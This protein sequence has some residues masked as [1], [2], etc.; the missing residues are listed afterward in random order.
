MVAATNKWPV[1]EKNIGASGKKSVQEQV[2]LAAQFMQVPLS[3]RAGCSG[4]LAELF[5][6]NS[7]KGSIHGVLKEFN[8]ETNKK[9][10][11]KRAKWGKYYYTVARW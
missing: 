2:E 5:I 9:H 6:C 11:E 4:Q 10:P 3:E 8:I 7:I 1:F